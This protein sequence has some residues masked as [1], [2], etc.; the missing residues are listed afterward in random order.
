MP[1]DHEIRDICLRA[2]LARDDQE[3]NELLV[4]LRILLRERLQNVENLAIH[5]ILNAPKGEL[6]EY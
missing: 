4:E 5:L 3:L 1:A 6:V 2:A